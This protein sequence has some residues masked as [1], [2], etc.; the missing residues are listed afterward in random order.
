[1]I[2]TVAE[3]LG[4]NPNE[5]FQSLIGIIDDFDSQMWVNLQKRYEF[6]S[7]IGIIDD[8]DLIQLIE[9]FGSHPRSFNPS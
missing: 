4:L 5:K 2:S 1:M 9:A 7:L 8:F 6:Q 3:G